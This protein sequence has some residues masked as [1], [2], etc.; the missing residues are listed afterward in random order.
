MYR[1]RLDEEK[2]PGTSKEQSEKPF[3]VAESSDN[4]NRTL[5]AKKKY[6]DFENN[7]ASKNSK[8]RRDTENKGQLVGSISELI[9]NNTNM[10]IRQ[11]ACS[12]NA[13]SRLTNG[14][15]KYRICG[16]QESQHFF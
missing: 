6:V 13:A 15:F 1:T 2:G 11:F 8:D 4:N 5:V 7:D 10:G 12:D 16:L 3:L 14:K 9:I